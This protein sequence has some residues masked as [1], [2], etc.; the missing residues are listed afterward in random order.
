MVNY[1]KHGVSLSDSQKDKLSKALVN[2]SPVT[3]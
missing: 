1:I 2:R 3:V